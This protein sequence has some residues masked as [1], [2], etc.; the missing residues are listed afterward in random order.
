MFLYSNSFFVL[1]FLLSLFHTSTFS[2]FGHE[3]VI[4]MGCLFGF[5]L[6]LDGSE[7]GWL[8]G[9]G[10]L[11]IVIGWISLMLLMWGFSLFECNFVSMCFLFT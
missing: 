6:G 11:V 8:W 7:G 2:P 4:G 1:S 5:G 3:A 10:V 9:S